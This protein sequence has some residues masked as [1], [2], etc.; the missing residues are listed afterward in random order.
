MKCFKYSLLFFLGLLSISAVA[1]N[2]ETPPKQQWSFQG[3][4]GKYDRSAAQRGLKVFKEV[5]SACHSIDLVKYRNLKEIGFTDAQVKAF[6]A[7][8]DVQD[9]PN[10]EGEMFM[11]KAFPMDVFFNPYPNE[12]AA[13]A[14]NQGAYPVDLS[15]ITK[16]RPHGADYVYALLTGFG[17]A[18]PPGTKIFPGKHYNPYFPGHQIAMAP[19]LVEGLVTY[20]DGTPATVS[21][22]AWDVTNFLA[23]AS[24]PEMEERKQIGFKMLI[25]LGVILI[26][27]IILKK[28]IWK[29]VK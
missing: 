3:L 23:W 21:Q 1:E 5:C 20:D 13:R 7:D 10:E 2:Q 25:M 11:R 22:M 6:A 18:V 28:R 14:A 17:Q 16:A 12:K 15:L 19:P 26:V 9:G 8:Y 24:E 27:L 29:K 4:L